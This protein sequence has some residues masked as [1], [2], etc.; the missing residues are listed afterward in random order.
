M[1]GMP[2]PTI[3]LRQESVNELSPRHIATL[4]RLIAA[5]FSVVAFPLYGN[6]VGIRKGSHAVL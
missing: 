4:E 2:C 1:G 5:G 3:S 6:A